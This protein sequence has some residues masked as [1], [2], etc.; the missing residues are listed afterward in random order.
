MSDDPKKPAETKKSDADQ[1]PKDADA[2]KAAQIAHKAQQRRKLDAFTIA[3]LIVGGALLAFAVMYPM[4]M[5]GFQ[6]LTF[7]AGLAILLTAV[8]T[9]AG[10]QQKGAVVG[11]AG[12]LALILTFAMNQMG[13]LNPKTVYAR[14]LVKDVPERSLVVVSGSGEIYRRKN[15]DKVHDFLATPT[16]V[17]FN[18]LDATVTTRAEDC[19]SDDCAQD[20]EFSCI[21]KSILVDTHLGKRPGRL[22]F[23]PAEGTVA[24]VLEDED[25]SKRTYES[26]MTT[27]ENTQSAKPA[28]F[29]NF[30]SSAFA[31]DVKS[32]DELLRDLNSPSAHTRRTARNDLA[33]AGVHHIPELM[34][35]F[36]SPKATYRTQLG[37]AVALS[38]MMQ[39]GV[40]KPETMRSQIADRQIQ[41]LAD[42]VAHKD[43]TLSN[44]ATQFAKQLGDPRMIPQTESKFSRAT[45]LGQKNLMEVTGSATFNAN[46]EQRDQAV[47]W[48]K[49][50]DSQLKPEAQSWIRT[51]EEAGPNGDGV[52]YQVIVGSYTDHKSAMAAAGQINS[53]QGADIAKVGLPRPGNPYV[54]VLFGERANIDD[55]KATMNRALGLKSVTDAYL[56]T[57]DGYVRN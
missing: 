23:R 15:G 27:C 31:E 12:A 51:I 2:L 22:K 6:I 30:I 38:E 28:G 33:V 14:A 36:S 41:F 17:Q 40:V 21:S 4:P 42:A 20:H 46:N 29:F 5:P 43:P 45:Q 54:P 13:L 48:F 26:G 53:E 7:A 18:H 24:A 9:I 25:D 52:T 39:K 11:G 34:T 56:T 55:A 47:E 3:T 57:Y 1:K 32:Y 10:F 49:T 35:E 37:I 50:V 19:F 44:V 16:M 8:G